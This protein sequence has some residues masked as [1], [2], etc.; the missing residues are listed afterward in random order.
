MKC[1]CDV[2]AI[3]IF[4][5]NLP[6]PRKSNHVTPDNFQEALKFDTMLVDIPRRLRNVPKGPKDEDEIVLD[7]VIEELIPKT[8]ESVVEC[9]CIRYYFFVTKDNKFR[10]DSRFD[11][12]LSHGMTSDSALIKIIPIPSRKEGGGD[13]R[14]VQILGK[15]I[16]RLNKAWNELSPT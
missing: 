3:V 10:E 4:D 16:E 8:A 15:V 11:A 13:L 2:D 12:K 1:E 6:K 7:W 9:G 5:A 14:R